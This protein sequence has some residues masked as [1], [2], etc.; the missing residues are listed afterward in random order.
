MENYRLLT[1]EEIEIL[2]ENGCWA[3]DWTAVNVAEE[4]LP[5]YVKKLLR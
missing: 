1:S 3:E 5:N 4:F 2:E